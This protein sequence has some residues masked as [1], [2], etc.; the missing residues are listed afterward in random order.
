LKLSALRCGSKRAEY[1]ARRGERD[2]VQR[3]DVAGIDDYMRDIDRSLLR[4]NL[5]LTPAQ[6]LENS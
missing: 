3:D 1:F 6:Q 4:E 2:G 5:K